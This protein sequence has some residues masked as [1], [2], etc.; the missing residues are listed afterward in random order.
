M[1]DFYE[2]NFGFPAGLNDWASELLCKMQVG[3]ILS[4]LFTLRVLRAN[5][6][7]HRDVEDTR[8]QIQL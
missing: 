3:R 4:D 6:I 8:C 7:Q 1:W 2:D 5:Q